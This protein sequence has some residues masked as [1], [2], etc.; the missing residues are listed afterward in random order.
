MRGERGAGAAGGVMRVLYVTHSFPLPESP[1]S[2]VGGMQRVAVDLHRALESL[3]EVRL[4]TRALETAWEDTARRMVPFM[5]RLLGGLPGLVRREGIEV[6]L[7]SSMVTASLVVPLRRRI[8][9]AGALT[10]AIPVGRDVTLPSAPYQH[11]AR[12]VL[13]SLDLVLP[14]SRATA[15]ECLDRGAAPARVHVVPCGVDPSRFPQRDRRPAARAEL[16]RLLAAHGP[17]LPP[18]PL[19]LCSVGRHQER[20][21]FHWF[22]EHVLPRLPEDVVLALGGEG[23]MTPEIHAAA[24]RAGVGHRLRLLG[25]VSEQALDTLY[26]GSDLFV[27]PNVSVPGDIEGF[28]VVMLEAGICGLPVVAADLEG[29]RDVVTQG[30][31]GVLLPERDAAGFAAAIRR[32][33]DDRPALA[34]ASRRAAAHTEANFTWRRIAERYVEA[35]DEA[36]ARG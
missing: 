28:G 33:R 5:A 31:N 10:A 22:V 21:G 26:S 17:P 9:R 16:L 13:H 7:F 6:V 34:A 20:K 18:D 24:E 11:L 12:R 15:Q 35:F 19:L 1:L 32:Y 25:R 29:I 27:M 14:I 8:Q 23:P 2:N 3:P 4:T 36:K 30:E